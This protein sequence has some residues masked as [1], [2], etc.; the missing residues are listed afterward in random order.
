MI[1]LLLAVA[2]LCGSGILLA[3]DDHEHDG[4]ER[5]FLDR[6]FGGPKRGGA[7]AEQHFYVEGC[8][9][10]H[11]PYQP[12]FLPA[13]SWEKIMNGLEDHFGENAE[14]LDEEEV[15]IRNFLLENAAGEVNSGLSNKMMSALGDDPA[16]MR[17]T[18]TRFF[19]HRHDE[20]PAR[21]V[22]GNSNVGSF[23]NCD[24]CHTRAMQGSFDEHQV[25]IPGYARWEDD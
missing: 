20:I 1:A 11:F 18:D 6:W 8:G 24:A 12:G 9:G 22:T 7:A 4:D 17:I 16:P 25:R 21:M 14:L 10:C 23:S 19:R 5:G 3:D 2:M 15:P 13:R